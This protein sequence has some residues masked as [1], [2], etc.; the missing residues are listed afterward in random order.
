MKK[1]FVLLC[2]LLSLPSMAQVVEDGGFKDVV[3]NRDKERTIEPTYYNAVILQAG[4]SL[5]NNDIGKYGY[6]ISLEYDYYLSHNIYAIGTYYYAYSSNSVQYK[7]TKEDLHGGMQE[8]ILAVGFG[9]DVLK[10]NG[11]RIYG[12]LS[13]G[14]GHQDYT[15]D[16]A[17][18]EFPFKKQE[19]KEGG[20]DVAYF[21]SAG[22]GYSFVPN[23]EIGLNWGGYFLK[24]YWA[25][26]FNIRVA[27][28]F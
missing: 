10:V 26:S 16:I 20:W 2:V 27:Y 15:Y 21:P 12:S 9:Y 5:F 19:I 17:A 24:R 6:N 25:N 1:V 7:E 28:R 18:S 8:H 14:V 22:Y 3:R 13:V 23:L 4:Y 11:H